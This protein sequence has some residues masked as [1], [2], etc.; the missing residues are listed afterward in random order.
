LPRNP[1]PVA[2][3]LDHLDRDFTAPAQQFEFGEELQGVLHRQR[4]HFGDALPST[5]TLR[6]AR[7]SR[8]PWHSGQGREERYFANSSRTVADSVSL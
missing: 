6:A 5:K 2:D 4:R 8:V 3:F 1:Q 7:L